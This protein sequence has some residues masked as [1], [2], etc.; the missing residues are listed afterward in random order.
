MV[1]TG[2]YQPVKTGPVSTT[3]TLALAALKSRYTWR[4]QAAAGAQ[5]WGEREGG[6]VTRV[7]RMVCSG[8]EAARSGRC[9]TQRMQ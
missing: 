1:L 3:L 7:A 6:T 2:F 4:L 5:H 8:A 9:L